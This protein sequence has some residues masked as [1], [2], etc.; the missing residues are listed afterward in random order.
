MQK[1]LVTTG[2]LNVMSKTAKECSERSLR[3]NAAVDERKLARGILT[4]VSQF[5]AEGRKLSVDDRS[6]IVISSD[7]SLPDRETFIDVV[8]DTE[9]SRKVIGYAVM[10]QK[11]SR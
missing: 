2:E 5:F 8:D 10:L 3:E 4:L 1:A 9:D 11:I 6:Y 7:E